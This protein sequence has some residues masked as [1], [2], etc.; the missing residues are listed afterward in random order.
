MTFGILEGEAPPL[1][2]SAGTSEKKKEG[3]EKV[4]K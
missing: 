1:E 4:K 3:M 2:P